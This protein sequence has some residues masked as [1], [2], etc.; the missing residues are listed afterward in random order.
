MYTLELQMEG[1]NLSS[2]TDEFRVQLMSLEYG[3]LRLAHHSASL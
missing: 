2:T 3:E 1:A